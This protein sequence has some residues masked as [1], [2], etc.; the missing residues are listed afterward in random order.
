MFQNITDLLTNS[1]LNDLSVQPVPLHV[2]MDPSF[3]RHHLCTEHIELFPSILSDLSDVYPLLDIHR[4]NSTYLLKSNFTKIF[5][6]ILS[7]CP[8]SSSKRPTQLSTSLPSTTPQSTP[9]EDIGHTNE[10]FLHPRRAFT[11]QYGRFHTIPTNFGL[12]CYVLSRKA[13]IARKQFLRS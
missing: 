7:S 4:Q 11:F 3:L 5:V 2:W 13:L 9:H 10:L 6:L 12:V 8:E 1:E